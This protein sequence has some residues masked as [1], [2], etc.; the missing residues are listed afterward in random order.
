MALIDDDDDDDIFVWEPFTGAP[1]Y[2]FIVVKLKKRGGAAVLYTDYLE[3]YGVK[4]MKWG[5]KKK[6]GLYELSSAEHQ[7]ELFDKANE[8]ALGLYIPYTYGT[9][10]DYVE[11]T[12]NADGYDVR[13]VHKNSDG[14]VDAKT[15]KIK[16]DGM[17][18]TRPRGLAAL[19]QDE[20]QVL[21]DRRNRYVRQTKTKAVARNLGRTLRSVTKEIEKGSAALKKYFN[22]N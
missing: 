18:D 14:T 22:L 17:S 2:A 21:R 15:K 10:K 1:P 3:H 12:F 4:G 16:D 6:T 5:K 20:Y 11:V 9:S 19:S 13:S 7:R 8:Y